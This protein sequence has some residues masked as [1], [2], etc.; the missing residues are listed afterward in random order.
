MSRTLH[1]TEHQHLKPC[2]LPQVLT[3]LHEDGSSLM[4]CTVIASQSQQLTP[5]S[6]T[7]H[8]AKHQAEALCAACRC[9]Q[10]CV[11]TALA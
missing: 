2:K 5:V 4:S 10:T 8:A 1:V 9:S 7:V 6:Q 3:D 11:R